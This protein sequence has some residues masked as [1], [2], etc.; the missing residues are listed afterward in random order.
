VLASVLAYG[1]L[2]SE[3]QYRQWRLI[4]AC[5]RTS[6]GVYTPSNYTLPWHTKVSQSA[7]LLPGPHTFHYWSAPISWG[8]IATL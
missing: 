7:V 4:L 1:V 8:L 5:L 6:G 2:S 3:T